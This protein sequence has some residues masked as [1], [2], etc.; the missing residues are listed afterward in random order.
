MALVLI[1]CGFAASGFLKWFYYKVIHKKSDFALLTESPAMMAAD[2]G[3]MPKVGR[4]R[5]AGV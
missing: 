3:P 5:L 2:R 4:Q 1:F